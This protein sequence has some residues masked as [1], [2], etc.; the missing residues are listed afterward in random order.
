MA[1][2]T[3]IVQHVCSVA[4]FICCFVAIFQERICPKV[5]ANISSVATVTG[6]IL[7]NVWVSD[8]E[9][10]QADGRGGGHDDADRED[11]LTSSSSSASSVVTLG[12]KRCDRGGSGVLKG[13]TASARESQ[14]SVTTE[15][16]SVHGARRRTPTT[17]PGNE[18]ASSN[19]YQDQDISRY[20]SSSSSLNLSPKNKRRLATIKSALLIYC[21]VLGLSPILKSLTRSTS[22]D[23]IWAMSCWLIIINVFF[24]HYDAGPTSYSK[25]TVSANVSQSYTTSTNTAISGG[26]PDLRMTA[27]LSTNAALMAS[28]LLA[29]RLPSTTHV[30]SLTLF[31]IEMFALFPIFRRLL[32]VVS[33]DGHM[34]LTVLL[35]LGAGGGLNM[36]IIGPGAG[37][38]A[39]VVG[40][41]LGSL[42]IGLAMG[43]CSWWLIG[44]QKYKN[45]IYGPW[46]PARPVI[47]MRLD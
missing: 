20:P 44:L 18:T 10:D 9:C 27:S 40:M 21:A 29:S 43:V 41:V 47:R 16:G 6:W 38:K 5:V 30:F 42:V 19:Q 33:W 32:R 37:W 39:A 31:S 15:G 45:E 1:G 22:S 3:V 25:A 24:F 13:D 7:W 11:E 23:S 12:L 34:V 36:V 46:D 2:L 28:T 4:I 8:V 17:R 14:G 26:N 35:V